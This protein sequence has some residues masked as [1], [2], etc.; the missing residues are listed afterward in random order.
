MVLGQHLFMAGEDGQ[1]VQ[2]Q[3][4]EVAGVQ[5]LQALLVEAVE[6]L[7]L[8]GG[9]VGAL[10]GRQLL[11]PKAAVLPLIDQAGE[12]LG[13]PPLDVDVFRLQQLADQP[14]LIVG[15][16]DRVVGFQADQ[17][18]VPAQDLGGDGVEGAKPAQVFGRPADDRAD[19]PTHFAR[20]LVGEGD[21][22]QLPG[23][24]LA[25]SQQVR[26]PRGQHPRL[27]GSGPGQH[28]H[29]PFD[30]LDR[31]A[32]LGVEASEIIAAVI[33]AGGGPDA[34]KVGNAG[35]V[36]T[37]AY[38]IGADS[39][40]SLA[41]GHKGLGRFPV[42]FVLQRR[43]SAGRGQGPTPTAGIDLTDEVI[44]GLALRCGL[45]LEHRPELRFEGD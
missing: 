3:V 32:L 44:E 41:R 42:L 4:A 23:A 2:Q 8:A 35:R 29:R 45:G 16:D 30:R 34:G 10:R 5:G 13:S 37:R 19:A 27:A 25:D 12:M 40:A 39:V 36:P 43:Q 18:G 31:L 7:A 14:F 6:G 1:V 38:F 15:V 11:G 17:F 21:G 20:R 33:A 28:Q 22:Q 9:K 26:Q 24:R